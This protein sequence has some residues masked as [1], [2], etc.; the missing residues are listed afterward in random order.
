MNPLISTDKGNVFI[1]MNQGIQILYINY[2]NYL[3]L[4][5][6]KFNG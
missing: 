1:N 6:L 3:F 2:L 5:K 4:L